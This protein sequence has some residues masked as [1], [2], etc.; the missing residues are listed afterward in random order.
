MP[1]VSY[2][3]MMAPSRFERLNADR[4]I[5]FNVAAVFMA[6]TG[7]LWLQLNSDA[8]AKR[9]QTLQWKQ[10]HAVLFFRFL[11]QIQFPTNWCVLV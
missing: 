3:V 11:A 6:L 4:A 1:A 10:R 2:A 5:L 8:I 7:R 9:S